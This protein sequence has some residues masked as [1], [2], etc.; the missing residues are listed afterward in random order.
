MSAFRREYCVRGHMVDLPAITA[1]IE[2]SIEQAGV[3]PSAQFDMQLAVE[4]ACANVIEHAYNGRGG[5]LEVCFETHGADVSITVRDWGRPFDPAQVTRPDL[6][7]PLEERQVGG[8]GLF[9]M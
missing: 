6:S 1:F 4:E 2:S 7:Q 5:E 3:D 9:L 8:L